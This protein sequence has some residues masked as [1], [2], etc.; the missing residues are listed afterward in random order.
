M[1]QHEKILDILSDGKWHCTSEFYAAYIAD[2]RIRLHELKEKGYLCEWRWC[3]SHDYHKGHSK[4]WRLIGQP[5]VQK[6]ADGQPV[7]CYS[8]HFFGE[9]DQNCPAQAKVIQQSL[10]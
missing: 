8:F 7:C 1:T 6:Y 9:H 2:P 3:Q 4:E 5:T 10:I